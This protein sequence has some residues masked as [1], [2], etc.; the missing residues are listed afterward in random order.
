MLR[1][2]ATGDWVGTFQGHK[3]ATWACAL[4]APALRAATASADFS[5]RVW[6]AVTGDELATLTH[7]HIV[8]SVAFAGDGASLV[9][10]GYEKLVRVFDLGAPGAPPAVALTAP[11][12]IRRVEFGRDASGAASPHVLHTTYIDAPGVGV[13][14]LRA[15]AAVAT[16]A[17][18]ST[19]VSL[20]VTA[21][22][23]RLVTADGSTA[24]VWDAAT[25]AQVSE[26][27]FA[28]AVESA[29]L[30]PAGDRAV[31]GGEDMWVHFL[32]AASGTEL[33]SL[34]GHHGPVHAV[35][36]C[37]DG[38][39]FASGSEDGTI[40]IW[41]MDGEAGGGGEGGGGGAAAAEGGAAA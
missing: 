38:A 13:W 12:K 10:G 8:R 25:R 3:G 7:A 28:F 26:F 31:V 15:G 39:S 30:N 16:I 1:S 27:P 32:D 36:W 17:T 9:T 11:D 33:A 5:A 19:V 34:K 2:G 40:R 6:D 14:D 29:S 18:P 37:P 24:R 41:T 22:G 20:E 23:R 4:D 35:R 21:D